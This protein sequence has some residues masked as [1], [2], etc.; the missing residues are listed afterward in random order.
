[1]SSNQNSNVLK[2]SISSLS[3]V[4][5]I[6]E[7]N[8]NKLGI[9]TIADMLFHLPTKYL[10]KTRITP[11]SSVRIGDMVLVEGVI[12]KCNVVNR[13]KKMLVMTIRDQNSYINI[14]FFHF[15]KSQQQSFI[16][17][18]PIRCFGEVKNGPA[19]YEMIHPE[20]TLNLN[21]ISSVDD[22][23]TPIYPLTQGVNQKLLQAIS[24]QAIHQL[25]VCDDFQELIPDAILK[26]FAL[27]GIKDALSIIHRPSPNII[28]K[29][30]I[31]VDHPAKKRLI[32][33]ELLA[34]QLCLR[35]IKLLNAN[36]KSQKI[37]RAEDD[38]NK[39]IGQL[40]FELTKAQI[41][42]VQEIENDLQKNTPMMRLVQ[43][44]VGSGKTVIAAITALSALKS[45]CQVAIMAP[46]EILAEQHLKT[47]AKWFEDLDI[48]ISYVSGKLTKSI[49]EKEL[50][51]IKSGASNLI[52][53][54]HALF[55]DSVIFHNLGLL[56][57][58]E[59]HRFGVEQRFKLRDK[60]TKMN[61]FPHQ[62]IM[63][64]TPIPRTMAMAVYADVDLSVV[65]EMPL[66]RLKIDTIVVS[67]TRREEVIHKTRDILEKKLQVYWVC[68]L[69]E[70]SEKLQCQAAEDAA[71]Y[72][73]KE[74]PEFKIGLIHG[75]LKAQEKEAI[76]SQ[77]QSGEIDILTAT[78]VVEVGIDIPNAVLMV[79][80]NPERLGLSQ[81]HQLRGRVGRGA[82]KSY[83]LLMYQQPLSY[84]AKQRLQ[85]MKDSNDGFEI[86]RRD[87]K[88]RGS[89][90]LFGTN[91]TGLANMRVA[92][93]GRDHMLLKDVQNVA[94]QILND[95]PHIVDHIIHRW[96]ANNE[97]F[98]NV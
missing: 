81:L 64:A 6:T 97:K 54:T 56:I 23:L 35:R 85:I 37:P 4:G 84:T 62:L 73:S 45:G 41:R 12:T 9:F 30:L 1:M 88:I 20:Y 59:Q 67:N 69:I 66:G 93:I 90:E 22:Y 60:C 13:R 49:K 11:L 25:N 7:K 38:V 72:L 5:S 86:A 55:Q 39:F 36:N 10:D 76:I 3:G 24:T 87:L 21:A 2:Q 82:D 32:F 44:D 42:V 51:S 96:L 52:I 71:E 43:G 94:I 79:I 15:T 50:E 80:E 83:C 19:G 28:S 40:S 75:K 65:D 53:G 46:T 58:D 48:V 92:D 31:E 26:Q 16:E 74:L 57:I 61:I 14:R 91:Q 68:P 78:T 27:I 47:F 8:L 18:R 89:G 29:E 17:D 98:I 70:T 34:Y 63:S 33:D 77:F 95:H